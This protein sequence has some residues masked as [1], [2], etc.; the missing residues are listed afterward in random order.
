MIVDEGKQ[1]ILLKL[2]YFGV[3]LAGKS[4]NLQYVFARTDPARRSQ[5]ISHATERERLLWFSLVPATLP[6]AFGKT[7]RVSLYTVP[8]AVFYDDSRNTILDG[9][10]GVVFVC[11]SQK[12]RV[13][14]NQESLA[15]LEESLANRGLRVDAI[16]LVLQY[17]KRDLPSSMAL[18]DLDEALN[19]IAAPRCEAVA[20]TGQGVFATLRACA[21]MAYDRIS[22]RTNP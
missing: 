10:D 11:D 6:P 22:L 19:P 5:M 8:G 17:N 18:E 15:Q 3:G 2:V 21:T 16:P 9:V 13:E 4:T 7:I 20:S 12:E 14:A 1:E